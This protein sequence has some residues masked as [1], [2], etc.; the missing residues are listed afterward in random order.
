MSV[1]AC[2]LFVPLL[3]LPLVAACADG[4]PQAQRP[5]AATISTSTT[6]RGDVEAQF[7][8]GVAHATG[9]GVERN[10]VEAVRYFSMA[11]EQGHAASKGWLGVLYQAG[12]GGLPVDPRRAAEL[13]QAASDGGDV[14]ATTNLGSLYRD[15]RGVEQSDAKAVALFRQAADRGFAAAQRNLAAMYET[16][17]GVPQDPA[18]A[19]RLYKLAAEPR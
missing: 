3:A 4:A 13:Y 2:R 18:E 7:R 12:R 1:L 19:V 10:D 9:R 14:A 5:S 17:R 15:G 6:A 11:A 16:G 8:L